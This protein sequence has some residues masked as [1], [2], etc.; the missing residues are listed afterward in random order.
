MAYIY[1]DQEAYMRALAKSIYDA[2]EDLT[3]E[4]YMEVMARMSAIALKPMDREQ[5]FTIAGMQSELMKTMY[6]ASTR[7]VLLQGSSITG[8]VKLAG[9]RNS[10]I[11]LFYEYGTGHL[12]EMP[13]GK[14]K[15]LAPNPLRTGRSIVGRAVK[16]QPKG[17]KTKDWGGESYPVI[18]GN[19]G[20]VLTHTT[21]GLKAGMPLPHL[22]TPAY[23]FM[24]GAALEMRGKINKRLLAA[25]NSVNPKAYI[26]FKNI[27]V[28]K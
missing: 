27:R 1:F 26:K 10:I 8:T 17:I 3:N 13:Q 7:Q 11:G 24:R 20:Y 15:H 23:R 9:G 2:V 22:A 19:H 28:V 6:P 25:V 18:K 16:K 14:W 5:G 4:L 12:S 21:K